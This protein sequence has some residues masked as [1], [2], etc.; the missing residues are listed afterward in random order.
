MSF[1][2]AIKAK[3]KAQKKTIVLPETSDE[4][5][6]EAAI[7]VLKEEFANI[8]LLGDKEEILT[9]ARELNLAE[10]SQ[11]QALAYLEKATFINPKESS[12]LEEFIALFVE[13]RGQKGMDATK[14]R[15]LL[16]GDKLYFG[17]ALV[18]SSKADGMVA[19]AIHATSDVL[20]A[21]LQIVGTAKDAAVVSSFFI[22][23]MP[24][25]TYGENGILVFSDCA[26]CQN[27]TPQELAHIAISSAKSFQS[28]IKAT[29]YVAMLSHSTYGSAKHDDVSKV[30][31]ATKIAKELAP[32][33]AIDGELQLDAA[34][35]PSVG[36]SKAKGSNVAG[37]ANVLIFPDLDAGNIGYKLV[38]RFAK[39]EAYGPISQGMAAPINDL[40]RGCSALDIVGV[41]AL[42][43]LQAQS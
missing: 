39:A 26:L 25:N 18:K 19:G 13:L 20:R 33:I 10:I 22:M 29:P 32:N 37:K 12:L 27:P 16:L 1:I 21:A 4:R 6:I 5:T 36:S 30:V 24:D 15:E 8:I 31:Q 7:L 2:E 35:V 11:E 9:K 3:A 41:V 38:Q 43:A 17:A 40:S 14:A 28:V 23:V 42:T 34:I